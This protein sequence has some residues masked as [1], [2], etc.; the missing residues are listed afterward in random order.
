MA[1]RHLV[2]PLDMLRCSEALTLEGPGEVVLSSP[3]PKS[4]VPE[5]LSQIHIAH[6]RQA[7]V[8][9]SVQWDHD[10]LLPRG[11]TAPP[12]QSGS[13]PRDYS[14]LGRGHTG[15]CTGPGTGTE[16]RAATQIAGETGG[17]KNPPPWCGGME[18]AS[19]PSE[20][21]ISAAKPQ[22]SSPQAGWSRGRM[23]W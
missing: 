9:P 2:L 21:P 22:E 23:R 7:S 12:Y 11:P 3:C 14:Q 17:Q 10:E 18:A 16:R 19:C 1:L 20:L 5:L 4:S 15:R 13:I 6:D 8:F